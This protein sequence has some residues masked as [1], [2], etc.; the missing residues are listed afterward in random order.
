MNTQSV[1]AATLITTSLFATVGAAQAQGPLRTD[2][3]TAAQVAKGYNQ[4]HRS[5]ITN[6]N[7]NLLDARLRSYEKTLNKQGF[8][9]AKAD[10]VWHATPNIN[11]SAIAAQVLAN[12]GAATN[13]STAALNTAYDTLSKDWEVGDKSVLYAQATFNLTH[14]A[15]VDMARL[16]GEAD[17]NGAILGDYGN[18]AKATADFYA[19]AT[20]TQSANMNL[21][22][23]GQTVWSKSDTGATSASINDG[24]NWNG[25]LWELD[26]GWT[27]AG[28]GIKAQVWVQG[29]VGVAFGGTC[30]P[31]D[32]SVGANTTASLAVGG[33]IVG[34]LVVVGVEF[35]VNLT[36]ADLQ[37]LTFASTKSTT[38]QI[39]FYNPYSH[40]LSTRTVPVMDVQRTVDADLN[41]IYGSA[42]VKVTDPIFGETLGS[43]TIINEPNGLY[44]WNGVLDNYTNTY[45][46]Q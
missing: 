23:L 31:N 28:F 22:L 12:Q 24:F 41:F 36:L 7:I 13:Q 34:D 17:I 27:I 39:P 45:F 44:Q 10:D 6:K 20:G 38:E 40:T 4:P 19:P 43:W 15:N 35:D 30:Q 21:T 46:L 8:T 14:S 42:S 1:F 25:K 29:A 18:L 5:P 32:V 33:K 2:N 9:L 16:Q 26:F 37:F 11:A 3:I